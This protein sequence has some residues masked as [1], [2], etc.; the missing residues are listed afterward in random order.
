MG[1]ITTAKAAEILAV[2]PATIRSMIRAG[3]L[4]AVRILSEYR[5]D[6]Q[7]ICRYIEENKTDSPV[8][9]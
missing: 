8:I 9:R 5:I 1:L 4:P 6:E 7:D 3:V 2:N